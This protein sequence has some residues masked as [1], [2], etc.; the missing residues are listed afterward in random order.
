MITDH[1][2]AIQPIEDGEDVAAVENRWEEWVRWNDAC[3]VNKEEEPTVYRRAHREKSNTFRVF[4]CTM[5]GGVDAGD[6]C[7]H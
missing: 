7:P 1:F 3:D 4:G 2:T 5:V 6:G